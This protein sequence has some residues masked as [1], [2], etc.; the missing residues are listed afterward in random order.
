MEGYH[1]REIKEMPTSLL[2][3]F[4]RREA[5]IYVSEKVIKP[6]KGLD[7]F[8]LQVAEEID[9]NKDYC[10]SDGGFID[11][12]VPVINKV[13]TDNFV[14]VQLTRDGCDYSSDSRR[15][16]DGNIEWVYINQHETPIENKYVLPHKF[17]VRTYRIHNNGTIEEFYDTLQKVY[18]RESK[19][20]EHDG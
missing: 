6:K 5:M 7:Y 3:G 4:S 15:Y 18:N 14:L 16:F 13:G 2:G 11:E 10:I 1:N 12:L 9:L 20:E 19:V 17:D 8:G